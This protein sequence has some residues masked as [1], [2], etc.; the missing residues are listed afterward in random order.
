MPNYY[1]GNFTSVIEISGRSR[2][3]VRAC[4][5][6]NLMKITSGPMENRQARS[7]EIE[8]ALEKL[9]LSA[10]LIGSVRG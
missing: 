9:R 10:Y 4:G 3:S 6:L 2:V 5:P 1:V 8:F 7:G